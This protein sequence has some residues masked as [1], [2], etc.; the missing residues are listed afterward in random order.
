MKRT[1]K[2]VYI[3]SGALLCL[4]CAVGCGKTYDGGNIELT[5]NKCSIIEGETVQVIAMADEE[6]KV[7]W[8]SSDDSIAAVNNGEIIGKKAGTVTITAKLGKAT[9][10]CEVT[11]E[12][13]NSG[14]TYLESVEGGYYLEIDQK[15]GMD[16]NFKLYTRDASGK[17]TEAKPQELTYHMYNKNI[18]SVDENGHIKPLEVGPTTLTVTSGDASCTVDVIVSTRLI[19][20]TDDWMEVLR[21][22]DNLEGY[23][24]LMNNLDFSGSS[25]GGFGIGVAKE[26]DQCFRGTID[27]GNH[28]IQNVTLSSGGRNGLFGP[29]LD[30]KVK[31]IAF[32]NVTLTSGGCGLAS[33]IS[34][35]GS[36]F[37]N[38]SLDLNY[39][40]GTYGN[41]S[42]LAGEIEGC[43]SIEK[44]LISVSSPSGNTARDGI[45]FAGSSSEDFKIKNTAVICQGTVP[46]NV[47]ADIKA[48]TSRMDAVWTLNSGKMLGYDWTYRVNDLP[49]LGN[50]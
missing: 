24:Y 23:Y 7:S 49:V 2:L 12:A 1:R 37:T 41:S 29:L 33:S 43:G 21:T 42:L 17:V 15:G 25:Y 44:C 50:Q 34:G 40:G 19:R 30:A 20:T 36:S 9:A 5:Q 14:N 10:E 3:L 8:T 28:V 39:T 31:N 38:V 13:D 35:N 27:G 26:A 46:D 18:A 22:T 4:A 47:P 45:S 11:V 48:F 6:G 16:T 32:D